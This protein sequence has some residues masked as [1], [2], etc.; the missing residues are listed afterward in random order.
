MKI[1]TVAN[2]KGGT[3]K[4]TS[5]AYL[6]HAFAA[7]GKEVVLIDADP[8]GS[9]LSWSDRAAWDIPAVGMPKRNLHQQLAGVVRPS[10]EIVVIDS[11]PRR[12][13]AQTAILHSAL[14]AADLI[15]VPIAPTMVEYEEL[16]EVW[17]AIEEIS[18]LRDTQPEV[19]VLLN[20]T[21]ANASSTDLYREQIESEG[22]RVIQVPIPRLEAFAQA[23]GAPID[24][25]GAY[26]YVAEELAKMLLIGDKA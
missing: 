24:D 1:I 26:T 17:E 8:Q 12:E 22:H 7:Q 9:A 21:V 18:G 23:H 15:V 5:A 3:G 14:R 2:K 19:A 25:P 11:P 13:G 10:T 4:T 16:P 20:R 6:A